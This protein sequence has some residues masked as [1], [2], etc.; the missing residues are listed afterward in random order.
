MKQSQRKWSQRGNVL[1]DAL[2][3]VLLLA[4]LCSCAKTQD[5]APSV[6]DA[7]AVPYSFIDINRYG[8]TNSALP[9]GEIKN[10][11]TS[12]VPDSNGLDY[13]DRNN[14]FILPTRKTSDIDVFLIYPTVVLDSEKPDFVPADDAAM[15]ELVER[16]VKDNVSPVFAGLNVNIYMPKYRQLNGKVFSTAELDT[17]LQQI[18]GTPKA[19][20]FNAFD[21]YLKNMNNFHRYIMFSHSQGSSMNGL[22]MSEFASRY[23]SPDVQKLMVC[24]YLIGYALNDEI[25]NASPYKPSLR[26][27]DI[28]T[29]VSWNTATKSEVE[30]DKVRFIWGDETTVAVNPITFM[31][32]GDAVPASRN[33]VSI[34]EYFGDLT[35]VQVDGGLTGA[36]VVRP[37]DR[38]GVF[39]GQLVL[40]DLDEK[41]FFSD[42]M[43]AYIDSLRLGYAHQW[44][45][46]LFVETLRNNIIR[47]LK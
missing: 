30:S 36:Q 40:I 34:M 9:A 47:R 16:W 24:S 21:F 17:I 38:G 31:A 13:R 43:I 32:N 2:W 11:S 25:L 12:Y 14:W 41:S 3:V 6:M 20:I 39:G 42:E 15:R 44:D 33:G 22:L 10:P 27:D 28:N 7:P 8:L 46:M 45:I 37:S 1:T 29:L 5:A 19:D 23:E 35:S 26:A 4:A 18:E